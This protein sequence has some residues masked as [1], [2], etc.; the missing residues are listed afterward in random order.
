[1]RHS[2]TATSS[3]P[4][5]WR[6]PAKQPAARK[7]FSIRCSRRKDRGTRTLTSQNMTTVFL[8]DTQ[9]I[10]RV[11]AQGDGKFNEND[12]NGVAANVSYVAADQM[13]DCAAAI[14]LFGIR[15]AAPKQMNSTRISRTMFRTR[16]A[17]PPRRTTVRNRPT[18]RRLFEDQ[19]SGLHRERA[20][21]V[22]SRERPGD[23]TGNARAWQDDNFV[24]GDKL[25]IYVNDKRMEATGHVQT[26]I[27]NSKRLA[28]RTTTRVVP[29]F[30]R[31]IR[32]FTQIRIARFITKA[33]STSSRERSNDER[34]RRRL[35]HQ[36]VERD[37]EDVA[38]RNVVLTQPNRKGTGD[39]VEYTSRQ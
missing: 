23:Y 24:R 16:A 8:K 19:E 6:A 35:S 30:A 37:G 4:E 31:L 2:L 32:C 33:T 20:R 36:R 9:D 28:W 21:R 12:R 14:R 26:T 29:V 17:K 7:P 1:M 18:A 10:E 25:V 13:C 38:Q 34:R 39:W 15:A 27:Y 5:I 11:D 3:K 22:S